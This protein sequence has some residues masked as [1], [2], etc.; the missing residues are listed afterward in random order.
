MAD[1]KFKVIEN[2]PGRLFVDQECIAC[3]TC[4]N[5]AKEHFKL[6]DSNSHAFVYVQ[7]QTDQQ[8]QQCMAALDACPVDAIGLQNE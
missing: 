3:D 7:P 6:T 5:L 1:I 8:M 4:G 2:V